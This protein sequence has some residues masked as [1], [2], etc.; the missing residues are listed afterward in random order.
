LA[1]YL[2]IDNHLI[3][4]E[5]ILE[6]LITLEMPDKSDQICGISNLTR[7]DM[8]YGVSVTRLVPAKLAR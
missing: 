2:F 8:A 6:G 7:L 1:S 3:C 5:I 4:F